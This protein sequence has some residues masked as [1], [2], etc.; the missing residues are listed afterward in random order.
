[1]SGD[2]GLVV[3]ASELWAAWNAEPGHQFCFWC[4]D[5]VATGYLVLVYADSNQLVARRRETDA[6]PVVC[7]YCSYDCHDRHVDLPGNRAGRWFYVAFKR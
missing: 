5:Q 6:R 2:E 1:M 7:T 3:D 4:E